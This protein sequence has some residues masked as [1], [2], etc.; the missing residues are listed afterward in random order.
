M[1][2]ALSFVGIVALLLVC[3]IVIAALRKPSWVTVLAVPFGLLLLLGVGSMFLA[4]AAPNHRAENR[5]AHV[6][7][8]VQTYDPV[9]ETFNANNFPVV[10]ER[11]APIHNVTWSRLSM[12]TA[13]VLIVLAGGA[14]LFSNRKWIA[15]HAK[16]L[17]PVLGI[18]LV[19][20]LAVVA[21]VPVF[22]QMREDA[23]R[24]E[25]RQRLRAMG[26][27]FHRGSSHT[28]GARGSSAGQDSLDVQNDDVIATEKPIA[29][30]EEMATEAVAETTVPV[31]ELPEW[32]RGETVDDRELRQGVHQ[33]PVVLV[34][35]EWSSVEESER[36]LE[37]M[38]VRALE[39]QVRMERGSSFQWRPSKEFVHQSGSIQQRF[40]QQ[41]SLKVGEFEPSMY[42]CYWQVAAT[43]H[44]SNLAYEQWKASEVEE[45]LAVLGG[46]AGALTLLFAGVAAGFRIDSATG[47]RHRRRLAAAAFAVASLAVGTA[48]LFVA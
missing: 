15:R 42:R 9:Y 29:A 13:I 28:E 19:G 47:G 22:Q 43:P 35:D 2:M 24:V 8:L 17:L 26:D 5:A 44:V 34:S 45:R 48:A 10:V 38:A 14:A 36:Q 37:K 20:M 23:R 25:L 11:Q 3:T 6:E 46:G 41:T 33:N 12:L 18:G 21:V 31:P 4:I 30:S 1:N 7:Q 16:V 40:V 39:D 32:A 27:A